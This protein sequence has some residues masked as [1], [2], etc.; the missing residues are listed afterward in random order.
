MKQTEDSDKAERRPVGEVAL[1]WW[2]E[3]ISDQDQDKDKPR[4][5]GARAQLKRCA[6]PTEVFFCPAFHDLARR[7]MAWSPRQKETVAVIAG[8]L[9]HVKKDPADGCRFAVQMGAQKGT[10]A[11]VHGLRFRRLIQ[12]KE[13]EDLFKSLIRIVRLLDGTANVA[14]LADSIYYWGDARRR[15]WACD[16]YDTPLTREKEP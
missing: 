16:Y 12:I 11:I 8:V 1:D 13:R 9:A 15:D 3:T 5:R 14:D 6:D 2:R 4:D 10:R 7:L